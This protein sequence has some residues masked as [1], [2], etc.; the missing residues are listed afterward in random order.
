MHV[1]ACA[2]FRCFSR[3]MWLTV[4]ISWPPERKKGKIS[5]G[6]RWIDPL[7]LCALVACVCVCVSE[8]GNTMVIPE[9]ERKNET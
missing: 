8:S 5:I 1:D 7:C 3:Y 9:K 2:L 6:Q 4:V